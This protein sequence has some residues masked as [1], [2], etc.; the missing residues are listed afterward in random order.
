[1]DEQEDLIEFDPEPIEMKHLCLW[2]GCVRQRDSVQKDGATALPSAENSSPEHHAI[3]STPLLKNT[4]SN[5]HT[6]HTTTSPT[7]V[8]VL[9]PKKAGEKKEVAT[10]RQYKRD[11]TVCAFGFHNHYLPSTFTHAPDA[12]SKSVG[13]VGVITD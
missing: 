3:D 9:L 4:Q 13:P 1:M 11:P 7:G 5:V 10:T 2:E 6:T 12:L 8:Q